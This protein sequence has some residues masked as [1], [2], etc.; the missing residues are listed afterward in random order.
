[1]VKRGPNRDEWGKKGQTEPNRAK[2]EQTGPNRAKFGKTWVTQAKWCEMGPKRVS[3]LW[4]VGD[5]PRVG[6]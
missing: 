3:I 1:M 6:G 4:S 5:Y 2:Q